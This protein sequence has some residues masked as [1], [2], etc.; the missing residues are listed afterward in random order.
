MYNIV[1]EMWLLK[2]ER[3]KTLL[4]NN[5]YNLARQNGSLGN[6]YIPWARNSSSLETTGANSDVE[7]NKPSQARFYG[8]TENPQM[9]A[10]ALCKLIL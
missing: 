7:A 10:R 9:K 8:G 2:I 1:N 4:A 3:C 5:L 6:I